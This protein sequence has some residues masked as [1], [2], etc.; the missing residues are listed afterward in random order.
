MSLRKILLTGATGFLGSYVAEELINNGIHVI[1]LKRKDS[2]CW[3]CSTFFDKVKW[4]DIDKEGDWKE[5]IRGLS[6]THIIHSA[7]E[8]VDSNNR[9]DVQ[10]QKNNLS[11]LIDLL[12]IAKKI[13]INQFIGF[14]S[15]AE[16][17][18]LDKVVTEDQKLNP[19]SLYGATKVASQQIVKTY[20]ELNNLQW[21][22]FRLFSF[23]GERENANWLVPSLIDAIKNYKS[24]DLTGGE[25][26]YAYMYARDFA[27]IIQ[28][29]ISRNISSGIYN[30]SSETNVSLKELSTIIGNQLGIT[31]KLNWGALPYRADQSMLLQ[32]DTKKLKNELQ[33]LDI[34]SIEE[35]IK[36][37]ILDKTQF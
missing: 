30:I 10:V 19:I 32:G 1:A 33:D 23:I 27:K 3:R 12:D 31:P 28:L 29:V 5:H 24:M 4:V 18:Y 13:N 26:R 36:K 16:Y 22:W 2:D 17:G 25:Q 21:L 6:P 9:D 15:Q 37:I 35:T 20:C 8:G 11:F 34:L 7:W 14:G